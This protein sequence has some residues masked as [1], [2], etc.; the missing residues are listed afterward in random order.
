[1]PGMMLREGSQAPES[2]P[3]V[4]PLPHRS[5]TGKLPQNTELR[6][7]S[8]LRRWPAEKEP[9]KLPGLCKCSVQTPSCA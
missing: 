7:V 5:K 1:M 9:R 4:S 3:L 8:A 2:A 6:A